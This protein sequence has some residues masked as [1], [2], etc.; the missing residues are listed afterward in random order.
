MVRNGPRNRF[1]NIRTFRI[2]GSG[3]QVFVRNLR[4]TCLLGSAHLPL[5]EKD[6]GVAECGVQVGDALK[7]EAMAIA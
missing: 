5:R 6:A 2:T 3:G 7:E 1:R 4:G